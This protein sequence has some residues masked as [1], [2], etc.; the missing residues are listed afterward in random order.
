MSL[1]IL[2][3]CTL[4]NLDKMVL[5]SLSVMLSVLHVSFFLCSRMACN[6]FRSSFRTSILASISCNLVVVSM[7]FQNLMVMSSM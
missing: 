3:L 5:R 4:P 1:A 6:R 7:V 2:M